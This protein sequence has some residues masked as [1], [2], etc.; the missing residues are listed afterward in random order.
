MNN[1][2]LDK[3]R[4]AVIEEIKKAFPLK[5]RPKGLV[6][7]Y[8]R[9]AYEGK[10][11]LEFFKI[12]NWIKAIDHP[13]IAYILG[14]VDFR[15]AMTEKAFAYYLPAF[16]I[17]TLNEPYKLA[18]STAHVQIGRIAPELD[19]DKL[20][21]LIA[22]FTYQEQFWR[23]EQFNEYLLESAEDMLLKLL[24]LLDQKKTQP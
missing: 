13:D 5:A 17:T 19:V 1:I 12:G 9:T 16:L 6:E 7:D 2:D 8:Y 22:Y 18:I 4:E 14:D 15:L 20:Q 10:Q 24:I 11:L 21:A 3:Q 23:G